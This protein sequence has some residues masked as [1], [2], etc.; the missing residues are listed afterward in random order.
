LSWVGQGTIHRT[1][2]P[3]NWAWVWIDNYFYDRFCTIG[4]SYC[5]RSKFH[6]T[7]QASGVSLY[8]SLIKMQCGQSYCKRSNPKFQ[9]NGLELNNI[10][11]ISNAASFF[12]QLIYTPPTHGS[13]TYC[14]LGEPSQNAN[15]SPATLKNPNTCIL[16]TRQHQY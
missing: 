9:I 7:V 8:E 13:S 14:I 2:Q 15:S 10:K 16:P 3:I 6:G 11:H 1:A 12:S 5:M 4:L